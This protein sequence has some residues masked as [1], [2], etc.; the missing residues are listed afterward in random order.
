MISYKENDHM[1]SLILL[2]CRDELGIQLGTF[3][4]EP[5]VH[6]P[7][8]QFDIAME[9]VPIKDHFDRFQGMSGYRR[10]LWNIA[11]GDE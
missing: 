7:L 2:G 10:N 3:I 1:I 8:G 11:P 4:G 5:L 6:R 9:I